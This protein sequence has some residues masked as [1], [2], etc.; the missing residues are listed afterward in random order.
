MSEEKKNQ[1]NNNKGGQKRSF[2][3]NS[4]KRE[5]VHS[6]TPQKDKKRN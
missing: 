3:Q 4:R 5:A 1:N 6:P 2:E